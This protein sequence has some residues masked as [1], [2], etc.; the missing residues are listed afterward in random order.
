MEISAVTCQA[1][2]PASSSNQ[3]MVESF[4]PEVSLERAAPMESSLTLGWSPYSRASRSI[5]RILLLPS[6]PLTFL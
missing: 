3:T 6:S 1:S 4:S 2:F 5:A